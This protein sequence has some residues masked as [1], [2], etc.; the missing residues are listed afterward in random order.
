MR[1]DSKKFLLDMQQA[2][3]RVVRFTS[4]KTFNDYCTD[5]LLRS[6]VERQYEIIGEALTKLMK[7]DPSTA[8]RITEARRIISFRNVLIHGYDAIT[9]RTV[10]EIIDL[11][12][13]T[14]RSELVA[15]L[16]EPEEPPP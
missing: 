14:L 16:S 13:P 15:L 8:G 7:I 1:R 4:G 11:K 6:G 12:L 10:W 5:D 3:D 9:D 2:A